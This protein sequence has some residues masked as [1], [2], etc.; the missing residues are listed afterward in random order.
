MAG[1]HPIYIWRC[2]VGIGRRPVSMGQS[3]WDWPFLWVLPMRYGPHTQIEYIPI[4]DIVL[5][6]D[7]KVVVIVRRTG[8][9]L[10]LPRNHVDFAPGHV[11]IPKWLHDRITKWEQVKCQS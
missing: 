6:D 11:I 9:P 2:L 4:S 8:K 1:W 5:T 10:Q 7:R 3:C